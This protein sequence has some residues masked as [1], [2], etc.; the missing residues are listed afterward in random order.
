MVKLEKDE[1]YFTLIKTNIIRKWMN[2]LY[3]FF[4]LENKKCIYYGII[5]DLFI[6]IISIIILFN[7]NIFHLV[8]I[9]FIVSLDAFSIIVMHKCPL[10][11]L[12]K[13][14]LKSSSCERRNNL[15]K[16]LNISYKCNHEYEKQIE[17][18]INVWMIVASKCLILILFN[19]FQWKLTNYE[20]LYV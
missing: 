6:V 18:L 2:Y 19:T 14:Y 20:K 10:T 3:I 7:T 8:V 9:L 11:L 13:K 5:H 1:K 16:S 12:E 17:L 15:L 4:D